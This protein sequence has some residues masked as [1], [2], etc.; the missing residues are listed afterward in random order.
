ML[1][2]I[3]RRPKNFTQV[4][5]RLRFHYH[6]SRHRLT[7]RLTS[8]LFFTKLAGSLCFFFMRPKRPAGLIRLRLTDW[9]KL[10]TEL[11]V[12]WEK[13]WNSEER[14]P[15]PVQKSWCFLL[16]QIHSLFVDF[17]QIST[18]HRNFY[19]NL[20]I[21]ISTSCIFFLSDQ[22]L[23]NPFQSIKGIDFNQSFLF[24]L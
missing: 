4:F 20:V 9:T 12:I 22:S 11:S 10:K 17:A 5:L 16:M 24:P 19:V 15:K 6:S 23:I 7:A 2:Q 21:H 8:F 3:K 13:R 14:R 1:S 18:I